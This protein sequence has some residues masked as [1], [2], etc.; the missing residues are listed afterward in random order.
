MIMKIQITPPKA[1]QPLAEN[2]KFQINRK[3][4]ITRDKS[5]GQIVLILVLI[6][7]VGL[8]IGLSLISRTVTDVRISSQIEESGRAFSAA[9]AGVETA[10]RGSYTGAPSS[11]NFTVSNATVS[12]TTEILGLS[13]GVLMLPLTEVGNTQTVW[14]VNHNT[15]G[16]LN[17][18]VS[19]SADDS[20]D[21]CFG[22][23]NITKPAIIVS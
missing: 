10:L 4:Y 7:V 3:N 6:T 15:D 14:L 8:T 17:E 2:F 23:D 18:T 5:A 22:K 1:D 13:S 12:Y 9:E 16:S 19:Y 21:I 11:A 20:F